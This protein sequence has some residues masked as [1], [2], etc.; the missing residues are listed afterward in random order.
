MSLR[1]PTKAVSE[2]V[3]HG[4]LETGE[5]RGIAVEEVEHVLRGADRALDTA[6]RIALDEVGET[7]IGDEQLVGPGREALAESRRLRGDIVRASGDRGFGVLHG[8]RAQ[9]CEGGHDFVAHEQQRLADEHLLDVLGEIAA[10]ESLVDVLVAGEGI[11]LLDARLHVM[12]GDALTLGNRREID[13]VDRARVIGDD[14]IGD[15]DAEVS[16][17]VEDSQ[18]QASLRCDPVLGSPQRRHR[19]R[20][21]ALGEHVGDHG[22]ILPDARSPSSRRRER[23]YRCGDGNRAGR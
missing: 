18:P 10:G 21:V 8:E 13:I 3:G 16:L 14:A 12:A 4:T 15:V 2:V 20:G 5:R 1:V 7:V 17:G 6:K 22:H 11:E 9:A 23:R 19:R